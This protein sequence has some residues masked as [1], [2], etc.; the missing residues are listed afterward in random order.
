MVEARYGRLPVERFL[1][2]HLRSAGE[3]DAAA[4]AIRFSQQ[5]LRLSE[6]LMA[7]AW[8]LR[9]LGEAFDETDRL[10]LE[11][12]SR[13][14]LA[15]MVRDHVEGYDSGVI[16][17]AGR[18]RPLLGS[19]VRETSESSA[20]WRREAGEQPWGL[21]ATCS[22]LFADA[23]RISRA[24]LT[25]F[26]GAEAMAVEEPMA[27]A[28]QRPLDPQSIEAQAATLARALAETEERLPLAAVELSR[29]LPGFATRL[30]RPNAP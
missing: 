21:S 4:D 10:V 18:L 26:S 3:R 29:D 25:I 13:R 17:L 15:V 30:S 23:E 11:P 12:Q 20:V 8:A 14:L 19:I 27:A 28:G 7:H 22:A 24:V 6:E 9:R 16:A 5:T 2:E 1:I